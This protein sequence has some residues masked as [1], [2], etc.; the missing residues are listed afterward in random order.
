MQFIEDKR[1]PITNPNAS[2]GLI[3]TIEMCWVR[4]P[5]RRPTFQKIVRE[6]KKL[7]LDKYTNSP[8]PVERMKMFEDEHTR[9]PSPD[10]KPG[11]LPDI[12]GMSHPVYLVYPLA[13]T[14]VM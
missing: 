5:S 3:N 4:D 2:P 7:G 10:M 14:P 11:M 9:R 12:N 6:L 1:P 8:A 13:H